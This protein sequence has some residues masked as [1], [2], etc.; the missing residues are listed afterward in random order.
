MAYPD[1]RNG[2]PLHL[3]HG[4]LGLQ[5]PLPDDEHIN[6][7]TDFV[8]EMCKNGFHSFI[9]L[10]AA[11]YDGE[12]T[13]TMESMFSSFKDRVV[14]RPFEPGTRHFK[15]LKSMVRLKAGDIITILNFNPEAVRDVSDSAK[16]LYNKNFASKAIGLVDNWVYF[17]QEGNPACKTLNSFRIC[18]PK[19]SATRMLGWRRRPIA[20]PPLPGDDVWPPELKIPSDY[21][22]GGGIGDIEAP[23]RKRQ[24]S[25]KIFS[26]PLPLP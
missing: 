4:P 14:Y 18:Y 25:N 21:I 5:Y 6:A 11:Q 23:A 13:E 1:D 22:H 15:L 19:A 2:F 20:R 12:T 24:L 3:M 10:L 9:G 16:D 8:Y 26:K 17:I 7:K